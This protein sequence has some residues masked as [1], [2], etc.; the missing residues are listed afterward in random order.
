MNHAQIQKSSKSEV[1][2]LAKEHGW[3][4]FFSSSSPSTYAVQASNRF[5]AA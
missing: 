4:V 1:K 3:H 5:L 2:K